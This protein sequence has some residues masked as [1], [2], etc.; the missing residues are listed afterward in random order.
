MLSSQMPNSADLTGI[1]TKQSNG[2]TSLRGCSDENPGLVEAKFWG[3]EVLGMQKK[4]GY[5]K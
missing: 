1:Q 3:L 2:D 5:Q 4:M